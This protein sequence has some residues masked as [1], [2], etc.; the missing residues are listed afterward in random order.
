MISNSLFPID[1]L[2]SLIHSLHSPSLFLLCFFFLSIFVSIDSNVLVVKFSVEEVS[3]H[4]HSLLQ[5]SSCQRRRL[6][7][8]SHLLYVV[9]SC[10]FVV[11][12]SQTNEV[13]LSVFDQTQARKT[14]RITWLHSESIE[15]IDF[16]DC[17][18]TPGYGRTSTLV[19]LVT[20]SSVHKFQT[21]QPLGQSLPS[22]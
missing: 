1:C 13:D 3:V 6:F 16:R 14:I 4:F 10:T 15:P 22:E 21:F 19:L 11:F 12:E 8:L 5:L 18:T 20:I 2:L 9:L 17:M 7:T